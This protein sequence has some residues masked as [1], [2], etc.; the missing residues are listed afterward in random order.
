MLIFIEY[1]KTIDYFIKFSITFKKLF[2]RYLLKLTN[3]ENRLVSLEQESNVIQILKP[4][5][6]DVFFEKN[7]RGESIDFVKKFK[8]FFFLMHIIF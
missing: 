1:H 6:F 8:K 5:L 7:V 4:R 2:L 3:V